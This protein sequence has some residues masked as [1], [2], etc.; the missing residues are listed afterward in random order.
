MIR[1]AILHL[2]VAQLVLYAF[3]A[4]FAG[5][6]WYLRGEDRREGYPLESEV[7]GVKPRGWLFLPEPKTFRLADGSIIQAPTYQP[8]AR[9]LNAAKTEPWP[10]APLD[11]TGDPLLA[12]VGPGSWAV[13]PDVTYKTAEGHDLIAPLRIATNF[14]VAPLHGNPLGFTARAEGPAIAGPRELSKTCGSTGLKAFCATMRSRWKARS[15]CSFPF[16]SSTSTSGP[17]R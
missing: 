2:D 13:R 17:A 14:A 12:G 11:P 3:F 6:I 1:G 10:G 8:D 9:P 16:I 15:R 5:L 7:A 4:F